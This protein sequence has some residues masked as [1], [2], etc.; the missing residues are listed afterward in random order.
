MLNTK[1]LLRNFALAGAL[2][3]LVASS[4]FAQ[5]GSYPGTYAPP[6]VDTPIALWKVR[7]HLLPLLVMANTSVSR[8]VWMWSFRIQ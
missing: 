1:V 4:A 7:L 6:T 2:P 3:L 8:T 5:Y